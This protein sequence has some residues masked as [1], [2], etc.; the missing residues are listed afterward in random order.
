[1]ADGHPKIGGTNG[2]PL[3]DIGQ[4]GGT[5]EGAG[6]ALFSGNVILGQDRTGKVQHHLPQQNVTYED[7]MGFVAGRIIIEGVIRAKTAAIFEDIRQELNQRMHGSLRTDGVLG[8]A[9]PSMIKPT[10][11][12]DFDGTVV[13]AKAVVSGWRPRG[14]RF[15]NSEWAIIQKLII[16]LDVLS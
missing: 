15:R 16:E 11:F 2:V 3:L 13:A 14:R 12:T 10:Q 5:R 9:D 4:R 7:D 6:N 8:A 1:M